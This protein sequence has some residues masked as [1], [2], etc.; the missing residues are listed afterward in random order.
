MKIFSDTFILASKD[1]FLF[2][3]IVIF[4]SGNFSFAIEIS[5]LP[6]S[7]IICPKY[8]PLSLDKRKG[9]LFSFGIIEN[10]NENI[11][12]YNVTIQIFPAMGFIIFVIIFFYY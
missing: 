11:F 6:N 1:I 5:K 2:S 7:C 10:T 9:I 4:A 3:V 12:T 8:P